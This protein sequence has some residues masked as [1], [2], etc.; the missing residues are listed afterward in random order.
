VPDPVDMDFF[1]SKVVEDFLRSKNDENCLTLILTGRHQK[2][3]HHVLRI[4]NDVNLID[5]TRHKITNSLFCHPV[6]EKV[7]CY[8]LGDNGP[9]LDAVGEKPSETFPWKVWIIKQYLHLNPDFELIEIWEDRAEHVENFESFGRSI[10][11]KLI[12]HHVRKG[13]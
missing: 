4:L 6:D 10:P 12:V 2:L 3:K 11:N 9:A 5:V 7:F 13:K 1:N 8:C